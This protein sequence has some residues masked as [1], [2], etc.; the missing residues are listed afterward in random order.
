MSSY[1]RRS[2]AIDAF[3]MRGSHGEISKLI[4]I[5]RCENLWALTHST[6][7]LVNKHLP[8]KTKEAEDRCDRPMTV[9]SF[10]N[11]YEGNFS[12]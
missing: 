7:H 8:Q 5:E 4:Q 2:I 3:V 10:T 9:V 11:K 1:R 12:D 6:E